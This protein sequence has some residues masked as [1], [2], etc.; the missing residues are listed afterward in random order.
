MNDPRRSDRPTYGVFV[1]HRRSRLTLRRGFRTVDEAN[2]FA[3]EVRAHR[4]HNPDHVF[5]A[6]ESDGAIITMPPVDDDATEPASTTA[7]ARH[8]VAVAETLRALGPTPQE[9]VLGM[10]VALGLSAEDAGAVLTY[11]VTHAILAIDPEDPDRVRAVPA[12]RG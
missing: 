12:P 6:R 5:I 4:F 9:Q 7:P 10:L 2:A 8:A 1:K 3:N 11:A